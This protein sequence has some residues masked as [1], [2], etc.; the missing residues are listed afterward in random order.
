MEKI[1]ALI[2]KALLC[3]CI[4]FSLGVAAQEKDSVDVRPEFG[5]ELISEHQFTNTGRY[6]FVNLLR[7]QASIPLSRSLSVDVS[8]V[9]TF[10]T[11][12]DCIGDDI[13]IF[14]NIDGGNIPFTL[15]VCGINWDIN[16]RHSLFFGIRNLGEDYFTT[17]VTSLFTNSSCGVFPT[18]SVNYPVANYPYAS[19]GVHYSYEKA[20]EREGEA[21]P[22]TIGVQA[23]LYNGKAYYRFKGQ[24]NIFRICPKTDGMFGIAQVGYQHRGSS[25]HVGACAHYG[26]ILEIDERKL[27]TTLW[28]YAEQRLTDRLSLIAGY[29]HAFSS[30]AL[31]DDFIGIGARY[32]WKKCELGVFSDYATFFDTAESATEL[33]CKVQVTPYLY[34][35]PTAHFIITPSYDFV[36]MKYFRAVGSLR[37]GLTF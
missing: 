30:Y 18:I 33:T 6:N 22:S 17:P 28:T 16:D 24:E 11:S 2:K 14:S 34:I 8:S 19:V 31:C 20:L 23:S 3:A 15:S 7:L 12:D 4:S 27:A 37:F 5:M 25:Y 26:D 21:E 1:Y 10:M 35:Q 32:S 9:S 36:E 13:Q 29:S